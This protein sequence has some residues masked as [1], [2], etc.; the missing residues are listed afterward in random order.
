MFGTLTKVAAA[1]WWL[2]G[3]AGE[4]ADAQIPDSL[5][6]ILALGVGAGQEGSSFHSA[7]QEEHSGFPF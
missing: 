7:S 4:Q 6:Q 2:M 1:C 5:A 3:L